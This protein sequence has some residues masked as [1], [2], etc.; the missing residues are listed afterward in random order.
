MASLGE[1]KEQLRAAERRAAELQAAILARVMSEE[2]EHSVA[3]PSATSDVEDEEDQY[4]DWK[5]WNCM[6]CDDP[7]G[8]TFGAG[9]DC[10]GWED[11]FNRPGFFWHWLDSGD[12]P[13]GMGIYY[14]TSTDG[15]YVV[16]QDKLYSVYKSFPSAVR[17]EQWK[18][19]ELTGKW[20]TRPKT[21][22]R[23][24]QFRTVA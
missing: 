24:L 21:D 7:F 2:E 9:C 12:H 14:Q 19:T 18:Y 13:L 11:V 16:L 23:P 17:S 10:T 20:E 4:D 6:R 1:L 8:Y 22:T 3:S 15:G 5:H